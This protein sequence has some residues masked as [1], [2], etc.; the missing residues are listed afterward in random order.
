MSIHI[1]KRGLIDYLDS[2]NNSTHVLYIDNNIK[3]IDV[4][5]DTFRRRYKIYTAT[6]QE[7]ALEVIKHHRI[8]RVI[9]NYIKPMSMLEYMYTSIK[10]CLLSYFLLLIY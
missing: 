5:K 8:D 10:I 9:D 7:E 3:Q 1:E 6:T 4:F 2:L